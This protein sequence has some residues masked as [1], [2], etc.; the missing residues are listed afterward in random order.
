MR[1]LVGW[2]VSMKATA[3]QGPSSKQRSGENPDE[4]TC[5]QLEASMK[6]SSPCVHPCPAMDAEVFWCFSYFF[7]TGKEK[8]LREFL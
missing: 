3:A 4:L 5:S 8:R 7:H 6:I 2:A 1:Q